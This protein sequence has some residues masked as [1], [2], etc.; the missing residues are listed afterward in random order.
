MFPVGHDN[1]GAR[2]LRGG[3]FVNKTSKLLV[4]LASLTLTDIAIADAAPVYNW[5][6]FYIGGHAGYR[7][8]RT[9][10]GPGSDSFVDIF[11][12]PSRTDT[13]S[14]EGGIA[15]VQAGY[16]VMLTPDFLVGV[17]GDWSWGSSS[18][19]AAGLVLNDQGDGVSFASRLELSWQATLR[20]RLG[21]VS[22]PWLF[23]GTAGVAFTRAHWT[24][25]TTLVIVGNPQESVSS[26]VGK[27]LTGW[28][29]GVGVDYMWTPNWIARVEYLHENFG[30][31]DVPFGLSPTTGQFDLD[32]DKVR[33][34]LSYKFRR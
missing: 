31:F 7:W 21:V 29:V 2:V 14:P 22:G 10:N 8:A 26:D 32:V 23:Y 25:T 1:L 16:N 30:S 4:G 6:G 3:A 17:E 34:A 20:A 5:T 33:V 27:T 15:G 11:Q 19:S 13:Y 24:D 9:S 12:L 18:A 28:V